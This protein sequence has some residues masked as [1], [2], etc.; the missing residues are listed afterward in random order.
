MDKRLGDRLKKVEDQIEILS[1]I[2]KSFL[3]LDA[4][5]NVLYSELFRKAGGKSVADKEA[6]VF[7][8][9]EWIDFS[10][11]LAETQAE[12]HRQRRWHE[13]RLKAFDGEYLTYK[14]EGSAIS[15][16]GV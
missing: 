15:R 13:L 1:A 3:Y 10:R 7:S 12:F 2:E 11:G 14:T 4:H 9:Q 5:K 6:E 16:Q 8:S